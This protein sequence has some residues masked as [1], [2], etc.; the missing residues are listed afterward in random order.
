V[1]RE[2]LKARKSQDEENAYLKL[3]RR[4]EKMTLMGEGVAEFASQD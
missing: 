1:G 2:N 3:E 4:K